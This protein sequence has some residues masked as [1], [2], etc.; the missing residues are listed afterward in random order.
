MSSP[1]RVQV[2]A[3]RQPPTH[4]RVTAHG[5]ADAVA[6]FMAPVGTSAHERL[7]DL[8]PSV[9]ERNGAA[10][11]TA[12]KVRAIRAAAYAGARLSGL[13]EAFDVEPRTIRHVVD[14]TSWRHVQ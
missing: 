1:Y 2:D 13:A 10:R 12:D 11:L 3:Y 7:S 4:R 5:T 6:A 8:P 9:G 14:G